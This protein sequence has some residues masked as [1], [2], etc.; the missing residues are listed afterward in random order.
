MEDSWC[1]Y[2]EVWKRFHC[3]LS[4]AAVCLSVRVHVST[5]VHWAVV[6]Q[7]GD[8]RMHIDM[9]KKKKK[10]HLVTFTTKINT[11]LWVSL[12]PP[13]P[14]THL[15]FSDHPLDEVVPQLHSLQAGLGGG[16]GVENGWIYLVY[17]FCGL[18]GGKLTNNAL[19][20]KQT[21]HHLPWYTAELQWQM[22]FPNFS[23]LREQNYIYH[24]ANYLKWWKLTFLHGQ[25]QG[26]LEVP[27]A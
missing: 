25:H 16:D 19:R 9:K 13:T 8:L 1:S 6:K 20:R 24:I 10:T 11:F 18:K 14:L 21:Q 17:I 27:A 26:K 23:G 7:M 4:S 22:C 5:C 2:W 12:P 3:C 15:K